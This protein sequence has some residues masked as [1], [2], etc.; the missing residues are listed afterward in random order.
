MKKILTLSISLLG[1]F[2]LFFL[3]K[4]V[5]ALVTQSL[6]G[7]E[8]ASPGETISYDIKVTSTDTVVKYATNLVFDSSVLELV[9]VSSQNNWKG[10]NSISTSPLSLEFTHS[11]VS[12]SS[13]IATVT[14][15]VKTD[16]SKV[17]ANLTLQQANATVQVLGSDGSESESI[18]TI[19]E[20]TKKF[21]IKSTD[22]YLKDLTVNG[23]TVNNFK[24]TTYTYVMQV[25]SDVNVA[26]IVAT[27]N[28]TG[29]TFTK[30]FAS[31]D[32]D[33]EYGENEVL[34][35]V[36]SEAGEERV[37]T[38]L[39]T[40]VDNRESNN[41]LK[42]IIINGGKI[43]ID[44]N[45]NIDT[46]RIKTYGLETISVDATC[47]DAKATVEVLIPDPLII[48]ENTI[49]IKAISESK[50]ERVYTIIIDNTDE[51]VDT[52]LKNLAIEG[53][54]IEFDKKVLDYEIR[55]EDKYK[56]GLEIK[57]N[58]TLS[59]DDGVY[60]DESLLDQTNKDLKVGSVVK[61]RVY[62]DEE[63]ETIYTITLVR[64]TRIN[65]FMILGCIIL[66]IL[67][68]IALSLFIKRRKRIALIEEQE[69]ELQKTKEIRL[70]RK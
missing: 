2:V 63:N 4:D 36:V 62:Y 25:E 68:P 50:V 42:N 54:N 70:N 30:G 43:K 65:F 45:R 16:A 31:R 15:K 48:G 69:N 1:A 6:E 13:V 33:L 34:V 8:L 21:A 44:F 10:A 58:S 56:D 26:K 9:S 28:H 60:I 29:A 3:P 14:F 19:T 41:Y 37:Y 40:R 22:N 38:I 17:S 55:Y 53:Y 57:K 24:S 49:T 64:D 39:I 27:A 51:R 20:A 66:V 23:K 35:K 18:L 11:G 46:Y 5:L 47:E 61:I 7:V 12:G 59:T 67:V 32:V 52:S